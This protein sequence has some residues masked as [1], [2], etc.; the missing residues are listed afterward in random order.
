MADDSNLVKLRVPLHV[1]NLDNVP[2]GVTRDIAYVL[3]MGTSK[4]WTGIHT[5]RIEDYVAP[6][7]GADVTISLV[8]G[9]TLMASHKPEPNLT[10]Q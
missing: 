1:L 5:I 2:T 9:C 6:A 10:S 7:A 4:L 3:T 8:S